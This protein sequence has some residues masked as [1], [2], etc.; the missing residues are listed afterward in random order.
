MASTYRRKDS[1]FIWLK[2]KAP[3]GAW[4]NKN[5]GYRWD[6]I[7]DR[8]QAERLAKKLSLEEMSI[9]PIKPMGGWDWVVPWI[10]TKWGN[11]SEPNSTANRYGKYFQRWLKFFEERDI[12]TLSAFR[13]EHIDEYLVWRKNHKGNRNTGIH[14]IKFLAQVLDE[15]LNRGFIHQ[16]PA[17]KLRLAK[18]DPAE[19]LPWS[20]HEIAA[21][22][23][24]LEQRDRFGWMHVTFLMGY[25]QAVRLRQSQI[26]L[27]CIDLKRQ[28]IEYPSASVK[29]FRGGSKKGYSQPIYPEFY[30]LLQEIITHRKRIDKST[31]CD[32]PDHNNGETPA[33]VQW[34]EF[35]DTLGFRHLCHHGL[36]AT[37]IT[38]AALRGIPETLAKR[39]VNHASSQVHEIYQKITATDLMPMLDAFLLAGQARI[40][41]P[42]PKVIEAD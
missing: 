30:P 9:K 39:F 35:L 8:Q 3:S 29:R 2:Y 31:L 37:W 42:A 14:E 7:G 20:D 36:R 5:S 28:I 12:P 15:A 16:N 41:L 25:Y 10:G 1:P 17:R 26:P 4:K 32:I 11:V 33:S 34:R 24:A 21:V 23:T 40:A 13:R 18:D 6:N 19:K 27:S 22:E 38:Q